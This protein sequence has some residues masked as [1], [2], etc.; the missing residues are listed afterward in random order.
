MNNTTYLFG[1]SKWQFSTGTISACQLLAVQ[2]LFPAQIRIQQ[3]SPWLLLL[4]A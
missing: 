2:C 1:K 4:L 3:D